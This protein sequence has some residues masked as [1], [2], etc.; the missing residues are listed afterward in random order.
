MTV[1]VLSVG[2]VAAMAVPAN[3]FPLLYT[4]WARWWRSPEGRHLFFFTVGMAALVDL[5]LLRRA[6]GD[7]PGYEYLSLATF[8]LI[9]W[10]LWRRLYLLVKYNGP[11][12][13][14]QRRAAAAQK[15]EAP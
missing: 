1:E 2:I 6:F 10:Q 11:R 7:F 3:L 9:C 13:R 4:S 5:A 8:L 12:A 14:A 15:P